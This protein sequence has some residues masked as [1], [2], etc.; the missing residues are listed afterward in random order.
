MAARIRKS[1]RPPA[2]L[3]ILDD[4]ELAAVSGAGK[5][6]GITLAELVVVKRLDASS[7]R[8]F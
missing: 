7:H 5:A 3:R 2:S 6:D 1:D 8:L 4:L